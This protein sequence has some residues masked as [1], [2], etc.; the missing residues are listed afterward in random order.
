MYKVLLFKFTLHLCKGS[1]SF[2]RGKIV[3]DRLKECLYEKLFNFKGQHD[4][5]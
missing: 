3:H 5:R 4:K 1:M 2:P